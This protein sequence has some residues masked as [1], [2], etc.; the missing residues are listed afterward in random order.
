MKEV[1]TKRLSSLGVKMLEPRAQSKGKQA[2]CFS[3][4]K[5]EPKSDDRVK[6]IEGFCMAKA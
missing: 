3:V 2:I 1:G 4:M 6:G 5:D